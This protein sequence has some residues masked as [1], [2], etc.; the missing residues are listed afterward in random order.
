MLDH[1]WNECMRAFDAHTADVTLPLTW[2][3]YFSTIIGRRISIED[4]ERLMAT[5]RAVKALT[6]QNKK[7]QWRTVASVNKRLLD[8]GFWN[9]FNRK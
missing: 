4:T 8:Q 9:G 2:Q 3:K 7:P 1:E 5:C 6:P